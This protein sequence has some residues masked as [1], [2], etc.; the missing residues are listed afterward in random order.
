LI[1]LKLHEAETERPRGG[2]SIALLLAAF[3]L[4]A[5]GYAIGISGGLLPFNSGAWVVGESIAMRGWLAYALA[6]LFHLTAAAG[7]WREWRWARWIAVLLLAAGLVPAVPGISA[8][9]MDLRIGGIALWG[10]LIVIRV[11]ALYVLFATD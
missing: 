7:V 9:V 5:A 8:A 2:A 6:A 10:A 1:S 4:L 11:A 3:A